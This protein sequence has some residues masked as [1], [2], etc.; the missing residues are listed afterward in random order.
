[1]YILC[2]WKITSRWHREE[3]G[4]VYRFR[5]LASSRVLLE[6]LEVGAGSLGTIQFR[7]HGATRPVHLITS[8]L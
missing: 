8:S 5:S 2:Y 4:W 1:M 7:E 6:G 3:K